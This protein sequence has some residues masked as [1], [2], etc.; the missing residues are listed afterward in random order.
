MVTVMGLV[1]VKLDKLGK[2][3]INKMKPALTSGRLTLIRGA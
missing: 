1:V 2:V 3:N